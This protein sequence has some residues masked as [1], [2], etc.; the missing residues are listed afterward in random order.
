LKVIVTEGEH[1]GQYRSRMIHPAESAR[2]TF[3][4]IG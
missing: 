2:V 1:T 4:P 3:L